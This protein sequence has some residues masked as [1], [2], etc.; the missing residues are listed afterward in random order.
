[1]LLFQLN[2]G[3]AGPAPEVHYGRC[4]IAFEPLYDVMFAFASM[5]LDYEVVGEMVLTAR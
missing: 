3:E 1:M 5:E 2:L 4:E